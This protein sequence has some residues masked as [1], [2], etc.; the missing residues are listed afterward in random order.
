MDHIQ[1][2]EDGLDD[3]VLIRLDVNHPAN[4]TRR[5]HFFIVALLSGWEITVELD[6]DVSDIGVEVAQTLFMGTGI[7]QDLGHGLWWC[8]E[9]T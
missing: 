3:I 7:D 1:M 9:V 4:Q 6:T 5:G 2:A 8:Y